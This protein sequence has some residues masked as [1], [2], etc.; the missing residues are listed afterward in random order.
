M[1]HAYPCLPSFLDMLQNPHVL[2][3]F[4]EVHNPLRLPRETTV[5][6]Q[7]DQEGKD[8]SEG[9]T[10]RLTDGSMKGWMEGNGI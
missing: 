9:W 1:S 10:N 4:E 7:I 3:A 8:G 2:L 5:V 6:R